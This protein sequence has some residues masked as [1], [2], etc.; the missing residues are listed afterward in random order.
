MEEQKNAIML[1]IIEH[2]GTHFNQFVILQK[3]NAN[4][5]SKFVINNFR[6]NFLI[7]A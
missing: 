6:H 3:S 5:I 2:D 1:R 7:K 4:S